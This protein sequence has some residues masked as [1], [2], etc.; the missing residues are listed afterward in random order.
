MSFG[1]KD[2]RPDR[3]R[4]EPWQWL[5]LERRMRIVE[6]YIVI[7]DENFQWSSKIDDYQPQLL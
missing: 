6:Q 5:Y 1:S 4:S 2:V 7:A 3:K